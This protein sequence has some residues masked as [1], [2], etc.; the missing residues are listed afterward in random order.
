[1]SKR[2]KKITVSQIMKWE[3]CSRYPKERVRELIGLGRTP[4]QILDFNIPADDIL[5]VVAHEEIVPVLLL[6]RLACDF[7][8]SVAY[9]NKDLRVQ[10]ALDAKRKWMRGEISNEELDIWRDSVKDAV[11]DTTTY[12]AAY[13]AAEFAAKAAA[14]AAS[15]DA[16][17]SAILSIARFCTLIAAYLD[18]HTPQD[19]VRTIKIKLVRQLLL[20]MDRV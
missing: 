16:P 12:Y 18:I 5:W 17:R 3:P 20:D 15:R 19:S 11:L 10:A 1:M 4:L 14:E 13:Y 9:L 6:H 2:I 8:Q 7:A